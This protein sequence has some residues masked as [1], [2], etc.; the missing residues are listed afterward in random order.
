MW[1]E[2]GDNLNST[3]LG[4]ILVLG[5]F[6]LYNRTLIFRELHALLLA[7]PNCS[8]SYPK[9]YLLCVHLCGHMCMQTRTH[10]HVKPENIPMCYSSDISH[11]YS[12]IQFILLFLYALR[13]LGTCQ[14]GMAGWP[15]SCRDPLV[16]VSPALG[17]QM[18]VPMP[19]SA[20]MSFGNQT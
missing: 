13:W 2:L 6:C 15:D 9:C 12:F 8:G 14:V 20:Y 19:G 4:R 10:F 5:T 16:P 1:A 7:E 3:L 11:F 17:L 18:C